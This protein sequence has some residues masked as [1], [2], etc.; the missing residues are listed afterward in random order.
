[1][2]GGEHSELQRLRHNNR[3]KTKRIEARELR[4][5]CQIHKLGDLLSLKTV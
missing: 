5:T 1:M 3:E 4:F 2:D